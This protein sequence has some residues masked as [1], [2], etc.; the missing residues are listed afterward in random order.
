[1]SRNLSISARFFDLLDY[2]FVKYNP[3]K[4]LLSVEMSP[5]SSL[6]L[7]FSLSFSQFG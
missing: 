2:R 5:F 1:M 6:F 3:L 4:L 7:C